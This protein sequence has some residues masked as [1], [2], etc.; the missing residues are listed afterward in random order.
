MKTIE[1]KMGS[2]SKRVFTGRGTIF[3]TSRAMS[4]NKTN[5]CMYSREIKKLKVVG[6]VHL[7]WL[8]EVNTYKLLLWGLTFN[9][10]F[11]WLS[12]VSMALI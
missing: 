5:L 2:K 3:S 12:D 6:E 11:Y 9:F 8:L 10:N 1:N 7:D 4:E